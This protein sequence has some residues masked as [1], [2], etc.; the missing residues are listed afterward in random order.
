MDSG[1][2]Y[3]ILLMMLPIL[4]AVIS[5]FFPA[6]ESY[7]I[8]P[9]FHVIG[10]VSAYLVMDYV[11]IDVRW[12]WVAN[13][14]LGM[15]LDRL[16]VVLVALVY[17]ISSLVHL[18]SFHY[19]KDDPGI[20]RYYLKLAF[21]TVSMLGLL[22]ADHL[23]LLFIFWELVGFS[24]YLLIGFW[25]KDKEKS[26][27][28]RHTFMINRVADA[29]LLIGV[30]LLVA[31]FDVSKVSD[32]KLPEGGNPALLTLAGLMLAIGA[33]GKSA[34]FPFYG[35]LNKAMAGPTPVSALIHAA[36]MVTAGVYL[37]ARFQPLLAPNVMMVVA[38]VGAATALIAGVS[39]LFQNDIKGVLAY[40][41]ISQLGYM[42]LGIGVGDYK[43]SIF[44]LWTHAFFKAGLF[45][46]AGSVIHFM[47]KANHGVDAQDMRNMGGLRKHLPFTFVTFLVCGAALSG[48]PFTSGFL[49]KEGIL[50][51][52]ALWANKLTPEQAWMGYSIM[53][54][55]FFSALLTPIYVS[56]QILLVFFGRVR[57][58]FQINLGKKFEPTISVIV[59]LMVLVGG[60]VWFSVSKGIFDAHGWRLH[61]Y[62]FPGR[63]AGIPEDISYYVFFASLLLTSIGVLIGYILFRPGSKKVAMY[64]ESNILP[65]S[66]K[67]FWQE[68]WY[69]DRVYGVL[70]RGFLW[71][72]NFT[73]WVD[74]QVVDKVV[75]GL[76]VG[77]VI[78]AKVTGVF[79]KYII[80]GLVNF[81]ASFFS[82]LGNVLK[83][84]QAPLVQAQVAIAMVVVIVFMFWFL[85]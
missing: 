52:T 6:R 81:A 33:F 17:I 45:L 14:K 16:N 35:W 26:T 77:A 55:V 63:L 18:F 36:T 39:A 76:G 43:A 12:H 46:A 78:I 67:G 27:S 69:V 56:R 22:M 60:S 28:A 38:L 15:T 73:F 51:A 7:M 9:M 74:K 10:I 44:H 72:S 53:G 30:I 62:L 64:K 85:F 2:L 48:L 5:T 84:L 79:D 41:T 3:I 29:A 32:V 61:R 50:L 42:M 25:F 1:A 49:S 82:G 80:D 23:V 71:T 66:I 11:P 65:N 59:P 57:T 83:R 47:H 19:M 54:A 21:F 58:V 70:N 40:S 4:A 8:T 34:Q 75:N 31:V 37:L 24:S 20:K 68:G 13:I